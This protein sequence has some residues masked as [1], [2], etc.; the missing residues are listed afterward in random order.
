M[1]SRPLGCQDNQ[2]SQHAGSD[3]SEAGTC[4]DL[5]GS[6]LQLAGNSPELCRWIRR[7]FE[8][9]ATH[10]PPLWS[11]SCEV[12]APTP[13]FLDSPLQ[14]YPE[15][16]T[17]QALPGERLGLSSATFEAEIDLRSRSCKLRGPLA[18]YP[19]DSLLRHLLPLV[20]DDGLILHGALLCQDDRAWVCCGPSGCGKTTLARLLPDQALCDE[21]VAV[22][23]RDGTWQAHALP[24]WQARPGG[25]YLQELLLLHHGPT[26]RRLALT[27][28][29]AGRD[30]VSQV[31]WPIACRDH[32]EQVFHRLLSLVAEIGSQ[33]LEMAPRPDVWQVISG[34][35]DVG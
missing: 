33:R 21:L 11:V 14:R 29:Q 35:A 28:E 20:L 31:L 10:R 3:H 7:R 23:R 16:T 30:L 22:R 32:L 25:G 5:A 27:P 2:V 19:V 18:T 26:H 4:F 34:G 1:V 15:D 24:F 9:F 6:A 17:V 8:A 12:I 13:G